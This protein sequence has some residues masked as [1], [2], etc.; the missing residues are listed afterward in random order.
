MAALPKEQQ[1]GLIEPAKKSA[2]D[3]VKSSPEIKAARR[4]EREAELAARQMAL[5]ERR[6]GVIYADPPWQ[7]EP[8]SRE[9]GM[10]Q[11][12]DNHYPTMALA[13]IKVVPLPAADD[14]V[15]FLWAFSPML[16][17]AFEVMAAWG[18]KYC[19]D[20]VWD[21]VVIGKVIGRAT[22]TSSC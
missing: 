20:Y 21:K 15:L 12:A 19:S 10:D 1:E 5:P 3:A 9:T 18:F 6:Y 14:A 8:Y 13:D 17:E 11:A 4:A 2:V 7:F 16:P 22:C